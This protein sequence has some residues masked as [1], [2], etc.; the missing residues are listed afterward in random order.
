MYVDLPGCSSDYE[1]NAPILGIINSLLNDD[2]QSSAVQKSFALSVNQAIHT[3]IT[4]PSS[5]QCNSFISVIAF[6]SNAFV[7]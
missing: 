3:A 5:P 7:L 6:R 1:D 2:K 4:L